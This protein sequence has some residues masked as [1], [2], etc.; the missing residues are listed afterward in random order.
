MN[1]L[2]STSDNPWRLSVSQLAMIDQA[3]IEFEQELGDGLSPSISKYLD[4][5]VD[6]NDTRLALLQELI[7]LE[8]EYSKPCDSTAYCEDYQERFPEYSAAIGQ[9][10]ERAKDP[11]TKPNNRYGVIHKTPPVAELTIKSQYKISRFHA[12]GGLGV[13]FVATDQNV[14]REVAVK[15][16]RYRN[17]DESQKERFQRESDITGRLEHPG[18]VP[19]YAIKTQDDSPPCYIMRF[20]EGQTLKDAVKKFRSEYSRKEKAKFSSIPFR[21][22]VQNLISVCNTLGYAHLQGVIHRDIKPSNIMLGSH[23]ETL[24]L[25]WGLA[26]VIDADDPIDAGIRPE[27]CDTFSASGSTATQTGQILGTPSFASPEQIYGQPKEH[28]KACDVYS[29][30]ATLFFVLTGKLP[31]ALEKNR[32]PTNDEFQS[33][34]QPIAIDSS[35][36][37]GLNAVCNRAMSIKPMDRYES[38][39]AL[40]GE[41]EK[42]LADE[43]LDSFEDPIGIRMRR[44][45][46]KNY[47]LASAV[48]ASLLV[49][50]ILLA[51]GAWLLSNKNREYQTLNASLNQKNFEL[52]SANKTAI[53]S[54]DQALFALRR[55]TDN[56]AL[57]R[58][59]SRQPELSNDDQIY[60][61]K[62][63]E[64]F[65]EL[66]NLQGN[67]T[68]NLEIRA[69]SFAQVGAI[70]YLLGQKKEAK[71]CLLRCLAVCSESGEPLSNVARSFAGR[72]EGMLG[73]LHFASDKKAALQ[74]YEKAAT[75]FDLLYDAGHNANESQKMLSRYQARLGTILAR[76]GREQESEKLFAMSLG[77]IKPLVNAHPENGEYQQMLAFHYLCRE[78]DLSAIDVLMPLTKS[79]P[80]EQRFRFDLAAALS[81][82]AYIL[83]AK[84]KKHPEA[85]VFFKRS[86]NVFKNLAVE[87]PLVAKY[88]SRLAD[89][90]YRLAREY[91]ITA[92]PHATEAFQ[93]SIEVAKT[94]VKNNP[95]NLQAN[96]LALKIHDK[97]LQYRQT[98]PTPYM[99]L[100]HHRKSC[101][102]LADNVFEIEHTLQSATNLVAHRNALGR[103][104]C[105]LNKI[106]ET[107]ENQE[108]AIELIQDFTDAVREDTATRELMASANEILVIALLEKGKF[109]RSLEILQRMIDQ[110]DLDEDVVSPSMI[111]ICNSGLDAKNGWNLVQQLVT[112]SDRQPKES[113]HLACAA[114]LAAKGL[115]SE[116]EVE[117]QNATDLSIEM[118][119]E[120]EE[121]GYFSVS[122]NRQGLHSTR[123]LDYVRGETGFPQFEA[124]KFF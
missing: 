71:K 63:I 69:E 41:L 111:A 89:G 50:T 3:C 72:A 79:H 74:H 9:W 119:V 16:S 56:R 40:A 28:T 58:W 67:D 66:A 32:V 39:T 115:A 85:I 121:A 116:D 1:S 13:V 5:A 124:P 105:L 106:D 42:Y 48:T 22:L 122:K 81:H 76:S 109:K 53:E 87:Y 90:L 57:S 103:T 52:T 110:N 73:D 70:R 46:K 18:I 108:V 34:L 21:Q 43:P 82:H 45:V 120:L 96:Q 10:F 12:S 91:A 11:V 101:V 35:I 88:Q 51:T 123:L 99:E 102:E 26:K 54:Q 93:Q 17:L 4:R 80:E 27:V 44:W 83:S 62:V 95:S 23:G 68:R 61:N 84:Q 97:Y 37:P 55:L 107:I 36:P 33:I 20:V 8:V 117:S 92:N 19:V 24:L 94:H 104:L 15:F 38:A 47:G 29:L 86:N 30:G 2:N 59:L 64:A 14:P 60:L 77:N 78:D 112:N 6:N 49:G 25:D 100:A 65:D 7:S 113:F 75:H 31:F 114:A 98:M 118:L